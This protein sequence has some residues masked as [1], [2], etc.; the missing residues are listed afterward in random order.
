MINRG[1]S[2]RFGGTWQGSPP[3]E[4]CDCGGI[5]WP[6]MPDC[7]FPGLNSA[8]WTFVERCDTCGRFETDYDAACVVFNRVKE[9]ECADGGTHV[10]GRKEYL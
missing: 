3:C 1:E 6:A 4:G 2:D 9:V 8:K 5:R 7:Y 10:I